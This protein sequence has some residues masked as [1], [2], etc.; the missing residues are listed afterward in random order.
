MKKEKK[1]DQTPQPSEI[2]NRLNSKIE[3]VALRDLKFAIYNP[4]RFNAKQFS[5]LQK[6]IEQYGWVKPIVVN[7][8]FNSVTDGNQRLKFALKSYSLDT[9][10]PVI[11]IDVDEKE[12]KKIN[13]AL[14]STLTETEDDMMVNLLKEVQGQDE[15]IDL[16]LKDYE[17]TVKEM[18]EATSSQEFAIV[19]EPDENYDY[20]F[21]LFSKSIDFLNVCNFFNLAEVYDVTRQKKIGLGRAIKGEDILKLINLAHEKGINSIKDM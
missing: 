13:I 18:L 3:F 21:A 8:R 19:S 12:D 4:K 2:K 14:N 9:Q 17:K 10:I 5:K 16:I 15:F 1:V 20:I 11:Y 7:K 6:S